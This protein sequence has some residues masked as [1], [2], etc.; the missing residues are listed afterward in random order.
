LKL[1]L[2][3]CCAPCSI[4]PVSALRQEGA[5]TTGFFFNPNIHPFTEYRKR[6]DTLTEYASSIRL[7][8]IVQDDY[9]LK[10]FLREVVFREEDRCRYCYR[11]RLSAAAREARRRNLDGFSTTLLYSVY[12]KHEVIRRIGEE[13]GEQAGVSFLYKDFRPGWKEGVSRSRELGLYRQPYC[14]CIYSEMERYR[15]KPKLNN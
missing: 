13:E 4:V 3:I 2:H 6:L 10:E 11:I 1:L 7:P 14:G 8:L 15:K 9:L 12:Q 5:E